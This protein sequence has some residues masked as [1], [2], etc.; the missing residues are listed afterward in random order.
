M[1]D[2]SLGAAKAPH[3]RLGSTV[4]IGVGGSNAGSGGLT[5]GVAGEKGVGV[6]VPCKEP[7]MGPTCGTRSATRAGNQAQAVT[8][9]A[10]TSSQA[11]RPVSALCAS[12]VM[13]LRR[14]L[15]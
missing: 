14:S 9:K 12:V 15:A 10:A 13:F 6:A 5:V 8:S 2:G 7:A 4:E 11:S 3:G 1:A